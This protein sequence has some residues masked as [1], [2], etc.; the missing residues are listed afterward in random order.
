M[1]QA[2]ELHKLAE[3]RD[4]G[5][6]TE[7]E[8]TRAKARV[9]D[10]EAAQSSSYRTGS[11]SD[12]PAMDAVNALRRSRDD[13]WIGGVCGG[14]GRITGMA[15]WIWRLLFTLLVLCAGSGVLLYVL[16]WIFVPEE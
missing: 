4:R 7:E 8:Y 15:S 5:A 2:D 3:L 16:L 1:S 10:G 6:L 12:A 11:T 9:L 13:R 14:L